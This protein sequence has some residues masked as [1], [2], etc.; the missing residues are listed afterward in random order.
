MSSFTEITILIILYS[1]V[2]L[3]FFGEYFIG[4]LLLMFTVDLHI[5]LI[6]KKYLKT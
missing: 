3:M 6:T 5:K 1:L 4:G 2:W